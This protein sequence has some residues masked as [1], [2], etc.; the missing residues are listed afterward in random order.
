MAINCKYV[1]FEVITA[2]VMKSFIL[3]DIT[4]ALL[5]TCFL[6]VSCFTYS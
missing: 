3:W 6:L 4:K 2:L 1:G 5:V